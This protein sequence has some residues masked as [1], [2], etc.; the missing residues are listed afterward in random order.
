MRRFLVTAVFA[1]VIVAMLA[2][3]VLAQAPAPRTD[4]NGLFEFATS[5]AK[6]I[7]DGNMARNSENE[8][9]G[10]TRFRPDFN[11][12]VGRTKAVLGLELDLGFGQVNATGGGPGKSATFG[13]HPGQT[14]D[15]GINTDVAGVLEIK[16]AYTEFDLTGKDSLMPFIP[17]ETVARAGLQPFGSLFGYKIAYAAAGDFPGASATTTWAPNLKTNFAYVMVEDEVAGQNR[18]AAAA[19]P[20]RGDDF[21]INFSPEITPFKGLDLKPLYSFFYAEGTTAGAARRGAVDRHFAAGGAT[22][23]NTTNTAAV[24]GV[25]QDANG[26]TTFHENQ[27]T[28][29]LDARWRSGP[30]GFDPTIY[31]QWGTRDFLAYTSTSAGSVKKVQADASAWLIDLIGSFQA[32]PLLLELRGIYS[33]GNKARDSL[34]KRI[35]Y[36]EPLDEDT[37]YYSTWANILAL[38]TDSVGQGCGSNAGMCTN[39][40]Y[41]RYGRAQL[42]FKATYSLTPALSFILAVSPTWTAEKVDTDTNSAAA[43]RT[44]VDDQSFVK[45]DSSYIGTETNLGMVWRFAPNVYYEVTGAW[46]SS[47]SALNTAELLNGVH[48]RRDAADGYLLANKIRFSY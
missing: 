46:L 23:T 21:A 11:F 3:P 36:F 2:P 26:S 41:D 30:F 38:S 19:K 13:G 48:T 7:S 12:S 47:G 9:Y 40:G 29:G 27:H 4:I 8:W 37:G 31:Y 16:W 25:A 32:G 39:V 43:G 15:S 44:I 42:G 22:T 33:T 35:R 14:S 20:T 24:F 45:G 18:G 17:V 6:N 10:R 1:F 28:I 34:A 5:A